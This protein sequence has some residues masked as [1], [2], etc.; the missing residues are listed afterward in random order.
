[1]FL[2]L[3][4]VFLV[5]WIKCIGGVTSIAMMNGKYLPSKDT[6]NNPMLFMNETLRLFRKDFL[7]ASAAGS[8]LIITPEFALSSPT[9]LNSCKSPQLR[10]AWC[11]TLPSNLSCT[12]SASPSSFSSS[13][14]YEKIACLAKETNISAAVNLCE[15]DDNGTNW[16]TQA[17]FT[18]NG[19]LLTKYRKMHP[20]KSKCFQKPLALELVTF[21]LPSLP[22][23]MGIF[24]CKDILFKTPSKNLY[25]GGTRHFVYSSAIPLVG[26]LVKKEWSKIYAN[27]YLM[28]SDSDVKDSGVYHNGNKI[29]SNTLNNGTV[30]LWNAGLLV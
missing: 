22:F 27:S 17:I 26:N 21:H 29:I 24:T 19:T 18:S 28:A 15:G 12:T 4:V 9:W 2:S 25:D 20:Y 7:S 5:Q 16:N 3:V 30:V 13:S 1:M 14:Y 6:Y 23:Q 11:P 8:V 10:T